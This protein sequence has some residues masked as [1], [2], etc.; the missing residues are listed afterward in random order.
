MCV[1]LASNRNRSSRST[2]QFRL[3]I[4]RAICGENKLSR[5]QLTKFEFSSTRARE[6]KKDD[7]CW[8]TRASLLCANYSPNERF[9]EKK[10]V[11]S[12]WARVATRF[13]NESVCQTWQFRKRVTF[14]G[15]RDVGGTNTK[16]TR[17]RSSPAAARTSAHKTE[18]CMPHPL[19]ETGKF[20]EAVLLAG[21][22]ISRRL[23]PLCLN[24]A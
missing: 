9:L 22:N 2:E 3:K 6:A 7:R 19:Q 24:K 18:L 16:E 14:N 15:D 23:L 11:I 12:F 17:V 8:E 20:Q 10:L 1:S 4:S 5:R 13:S 21:W